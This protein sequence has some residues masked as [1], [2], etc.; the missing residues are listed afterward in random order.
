MS[1]S[2]ADSG[3]RIENRDAVDPTAEEGCRSPLTRNTRWRYFP[4]ERGAG[5]TF[6]R[7]GSSEI[8]DFCSQSLNLSLGH[9]HPEI[10]RA[11]SEAMDR[12]TF[13]SSRFTS[14]YAME[15]AYSM[16][17]AAPGDLCKVN[18]KVTSGTLA[19]EAALKAA[20]KRTGCTGV[21]SL[22]GSHH[23]QSIATMRVSGK[24]LSLPYVDR[25]G[26]DYLSPC[27]CSSRYG[28]DDCRGDC[29]EPI[30]DHLERRKGSIA[31]I[32]LEP[33][34]VDAGVIVLPRTFLAG[35]RKL[36]D[37]YG[38]SLVFDEVQTA[39]GWTGEIFACEHSGVVPDALTGSKGFAAG[40]PAA[41][42]L[43][44]EEMDVLDYGEHEITHG[45]HPLSCAA[46]LANLRILTE[47]NLL[48][49]VRRLGGYLFDQLV[50]LQREHSIVEEVRGIGFVLGLVLR[51]GTR[52]SAG[53]E[54]VESCLDSGLLVRLSKVGERGNVVQIK[55]PLVTSRDEIDRALDILRSSLRRI[56]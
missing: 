49:Q 26:V 27:I 10:N 17:E 48:E 41:F 44:R 20:F 23:G 6:N 54:L 39:F 8:L 35:L 42:A 56:V 47:T 25:T 9:C 14:D 36:A 1:S 45:A 22:M 21:I 30:R 5:V 29:I 33:V 46:A 15:L 28:T 13:I 31:A 55:P 37:E 24:N 4:V 16:V 52:E 50:E 51:N 34:M 3:S 11:L 12:M 40:L 19:N 18:L 7:R 43:F 38:V 32:I 53:R 2:S